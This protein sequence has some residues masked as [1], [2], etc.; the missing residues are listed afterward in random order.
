MPFQDVEEVAENEYPSPPGLI[1]GWLR[2][3][4][5]EDWALKLLALAITLLLWLAVTGV[6][7][8]VTIRTGVQLN[9]IRPDKLDISN[10]P[11]RT[12]DVLLTGRRSNLD[13]ISKLDLVATV[14]VSDQHEGERVVRLTSDRVQME[15]P[16]GVK[17]ESFQ[18]STIPI[19]LERIVDRQVAVEVKLAG[20]L[21]EAH[22]VYS[23]RANPNVITV[24]GP[25]GHVTAMKDA[26]T[27]SISL[28]GKQETF[29]VPH[30]S[31]DVADNK[32]DLLNTTVDVTVE[33]GERRAEKTFAGISV[34]SDQGGTPQ[35][36]TA[37]VTVYGPLSVINQL[38]SSELSV[39]L[40]RAADN[41]LAPHLQLPAAVRDRVTMKS[42]KPAQ[43]T[44]SR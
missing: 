4:F 11:P 29:V 38:S 8:P 2:K 12:V 9:F 17:I 44:V 28:D 35:P 13:K 19:D 5:I 1:Q 10:D 31:I 32:I 7:K 22:E 43:F 20:K 30:V 34:T 21:D 40:T 15:L 3:I 25:V 41:T 42:I 26:P 24:R 6:N 14:D 27:E 39:T 23:V 33:I 16:D 36:Q 37:S 18:P